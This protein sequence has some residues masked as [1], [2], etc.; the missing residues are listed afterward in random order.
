MYEKRL[1]YAHESV[2]AASGSSLTFDSALSRT[3]SEYPDNWSELRAQGL[4]YFQ[5]K[6]KLD[7]DSSREK[8]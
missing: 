1:H 7:H 5:Y 3:F 8:S 6:V 2:A 4:V